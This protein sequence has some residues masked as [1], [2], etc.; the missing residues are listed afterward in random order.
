M[1]FSEIIWNLEFALFLEN[2]I[3]LL[4]YIKENLI[5]ESIKESN[6]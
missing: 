2:V 5:Q 1:N 3:D 4:N 6:Y